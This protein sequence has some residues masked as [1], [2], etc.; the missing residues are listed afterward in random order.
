MEIAEEVHHRGHR[1][2]MKRIP[3]AT[4]REKLHLRNQGAA[5]GFTLKL[6]RY[7]GKA[8][9]SLTGEGVSYTCEVGPA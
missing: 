4:T 7:K 6:E 1:R 3:T 8:R 9:K 5:P 2:R